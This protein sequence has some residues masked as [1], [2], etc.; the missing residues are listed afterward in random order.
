MTIDPTAIV[1]FAENA[2][3]PTL[4]T[5][6]DAWQALVGDRIA[7]WRLTNAA[8]I[9]KHVEIELR[10]LGVALDRAKIP[11]RYAFSWFEKASEQDEPEIQTLFARLLAEAMN[12][13]EDSL[14]RRNLELLGKFT[15]REAET[16]QWVIDKYGRSDMG[17]D[18][19][20]MIF[21][22]SGTIEFHVGK[23]F[24]IR[25]W[26]AI[27]Y[28]ISLGIFQWVAGTELND[29]KKFMED[30]ASEPDIE[31]NFIRDNKYPFYK[32]IMITE[33]GRSLRRAVG[34]FNQI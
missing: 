7:A 9:Q 31:N 26:I 24:G 20:I 3:Q 18:G 10:N 23:C 12:S 11:D 22:R 2:V 5:L 14:D 13:N 6:S 4:G 28:M 25:G 17:L 8:K 19:D 15:P 32:Y 1:K 33:L 27:E 34:R 16:F 29:L 21:E 30:I